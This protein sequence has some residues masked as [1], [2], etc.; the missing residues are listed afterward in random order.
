MWT[1]GS[2]SSSHPTVTARGCPR[3]ASRPQVPAGAQR[4][5]T[6]RWAHRRVH[7]RAAAAGLEHV[8]PAARRQPRARAQTRSQDA[9]LPGPRARQR[10][11]LPAHDTGPP[12][13]N[14][15]PPEPAAGFPDPTC[16]ARRGRAHSATHFLR[17]RHA[18]GPR[19]YP[20]ADARGRAG[21][22]CPPRAPRPG[23]YTHAASRPRPRA[24]RGLSVWR[25]G[26][27]SR[28]GGRRRPSGEAAAPGRGGGGASGCPS[29]ASL[30]LPHRDTLPPAPRGFSRGFEGSS[31]AA[32]PSSA[33]ARP[34]SW[35]CGKRRPV[36]RG[37]T[38]SYAVTRGRTRS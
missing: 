5:R 15:E 30:R 22:V 4:Q 18:R 14:E 33:A 32:L 25:C 12:A 11:G 29:P 21:Q 24:W 8:L 31:R 20:P 36:A 17:P 10:R 6:H 26:R 16:P 34:R 37:R 28:S 1:E 2:R 35:G 7:W 23:P 3:P 13:R 19:T 38:W 9:E 27:W